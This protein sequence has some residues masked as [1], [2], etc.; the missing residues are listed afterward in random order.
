MVK[1]EHIIKAMDLYITKCPT[2]AQMKQ[3]IGQ[4][5]VDEM[6]Q[7]LQDRKLLN[8]LEIDDYKEIWSYLKSTISLKD[9]ID[10][11][12]MDVY[13]QIVQQ[14]T[15]TTKEEL[16]QY[17]RR[18][19]EGLRR[20]ELPIIDLSKYS[21]DTQY[22]W[23]DMIAEIEDNEKIIGDLELRQIEAQKKSIDLT[24]R[25]D[26]DFRFDE[27]M[28]AM[29]CY[30]S[31]D[32]QHLN[33]SII[34]EKYLYKLRDIQKKDIKY[35]DEIMKESPGL[36]KDTVLFRGGSWDI[37]LNVG[38]H[39]NGFKGYQSTTF[40]EDTAQSYKDSYDL[41]KF[42]IANEY[43]KKGMLV[44]IYAPKG[45][46]GLCGNDDRFVNGF[47]EHEFVLPRNQGFTVLS[48]D[49]DKMEAEIVLDE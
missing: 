36:I 19:F 21:E 47:A 6:F 42:E 43:P 2:I 3:R 11:S 17:N 28:V 30:F 23:D 27:K 5:S 7:Q 49:Y 12:K 34:D 33:Y 1:Y 22:R 41:G 13:E 38:D 18:L 37:H 15:E 39:S 40:Q 35:I 46:K 48:I 31:G 44:K 9:E 45:T 25:N 29:N 24:P 16:F 4:M 10:P 8:P 20:S 14:Q 32:C 26:Y